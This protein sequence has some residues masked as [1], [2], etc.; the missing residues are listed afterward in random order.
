[1]VGYS[2]S[3]IRNCAA[4]NQIVTASSSYGSGR[5]CGPGYFND[6]G[7]GTFLNNY[8]RNN[9]GTG[10]GVAF[11]GGDDNGTDVTTA[12]YSTQDFWQTK[13][14]WNFATIWQWDSGKRLPVLR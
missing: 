2:I 3:I 10:G 8:A 6:G 14:A 1:V 4:L 12:T 7:N 9:I 5:V 13:L 11:N